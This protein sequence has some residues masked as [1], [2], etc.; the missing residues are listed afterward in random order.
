MCTAY[1][2]TYVDAPPQRHTC[3]RPHAREH[4]AHVTL[5]AVRA[6]GSGDV[7]AAHIPHIH[8]YAR[9]R[10]HNATQLDCISAHA[11]RRPQNTTP[12]TMVGQRRRQQFNRQHVLHESVRRSREHAPRDVQRQC[13][14][15]SERARQEL[16]MNPS[17]QMRRPMNMELMR[18]SFEWVCLSRRCAFSWKIHR[19][20]TSMRSINSSRI[21]SSQG[22]L[23]CST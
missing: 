22:T 1:V 16:V 12:P 20:V 6:A 13:G 17:A 4:R 19:T 2:C 14:R 9:T 11:G 5:H 7:H 3:A 21:L 10:A 15:G 18:R 23:H 8:T